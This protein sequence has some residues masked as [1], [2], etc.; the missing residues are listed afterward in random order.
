MTTMLV[1]LWAILKWIAMIFFTVGSLMYFCCAVLLVLFVIGA[2][3]TGK[4]WDG[5]ER[6]P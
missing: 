1:T 2:I 6:E 4:A 3:G 5:R